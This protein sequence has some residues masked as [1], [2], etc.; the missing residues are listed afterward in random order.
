MSSSYL[1][2]DDFL[3]FIYLLKQKFYRNL[4]NGKTKYEALSEAQHYVR[5]YKAERIQELTPNQRRRME[6]Q[7]KKVEAKVQIVYPYSNPR[8]WAGFVL[9]DGM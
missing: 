8:Y 1:R 3:S 6:L 7:G 4:V 5:E 2:D 9:L